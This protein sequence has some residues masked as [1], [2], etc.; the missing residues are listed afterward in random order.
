[1]LKRIWSVMQKEFIEIFRDRRT[2]MIQLLIP[3]VQLIL[4]GYAVET[5]VDH[6]PTVVADYSRDNQSRAFIEALQNTGY[7]DIA[8]YVAGEKEVIDAIDRSDAR[9]GVVIQAGFA[10]GIARRTTPQVLILID[11]SDPA[12]SSSALS[13]ATAAGQNF[14][15]ELSFEQLERA[16]IGALMTSPI[17][18][19]P[20][21]L[22]NPSMRAIN[23]MLP[24]I[25]G[26]VLQW[27]ALL[28]TTFAIVRE[29]GTLE[30]ILV[31]PIRPFELMIG[32]V[33]PYLFLAVVNMLSV[34]LLELWW[35]QVPFNGSIG[36]F[37][38]VTLIFILTSLSMGIL[39]ST[40]AATHNQANQLSIL[41]L[42]PSLVLSGYIFPREAMPLII[43]DI[44]YLLPLTYYLQ[45]LRGIMIKGVG[46]E[47]LM[48]SIVPMAVYG[49]A[50]FLLAVTSFKQNLE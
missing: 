37:W 33:V 23:F 40:V 46:M 42:L 47:H 31:T 14:A 30:Q 3:V 48:P 50:M 22:Y 11:G 5:Q 29:R 17:D 43:H 2:L 4:F 1:M 28:L 9:A 20:R 34:L 13:A 49:V 7:F 39:L 44:G 12:I 24:A 16:G 38:V 36:L 15:V 26:L 18:V 6:L 45:I 32:K 21:L 27:Q 8:D 41:I 19:R 35:F 25:I 10:A